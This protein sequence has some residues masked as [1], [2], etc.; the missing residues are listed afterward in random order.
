MIRLDL[1]HQIAQRL[2][3]RIKSHLQRPQAPQQPPGV[4]ELAG[5]CLGA[6]RE[7]VQMTL[8]W[9]RPEVLVSGIRPPVLGDWR[10]QMKDDFTESQQRS[11]HLS[12][13]ACDGGD[14]SREADGSSDS[15]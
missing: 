2:L 7:V 6:A 5:C 8:E 10:E 3:E 9:A 11:Q 15:P 14:Q 4:F 1:E 12:P 13:V